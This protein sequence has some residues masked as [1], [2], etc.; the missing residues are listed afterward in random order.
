MKVVYRKRMVE[1]LNEAIAEANRQGKE[2]EKFLL[3]AEEMD[4][5]DRETRLV[6]RH[7]T[8]MVKYPSGILFNGIPVELYEVKEDF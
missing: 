3:T 4:R 7:R 8:P 5:L 2:I 1:Q 6:T